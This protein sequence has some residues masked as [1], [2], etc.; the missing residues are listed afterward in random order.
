MVAGL[1]APTAAQTG[2]HGFLGGGSDCRRSA[3]GRPTLPGQLRIDKA[4]P[5]SLTGR[6]A[7]QDQLRYSH[8]LHAGAVQTSFSPRWKR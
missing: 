7:Q 2:T 4:L 3:V 6:I 1:V 5:L 8:H